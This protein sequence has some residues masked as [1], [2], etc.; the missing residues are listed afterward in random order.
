MTIT[1]IEL[2]ATAIHLRRD[3]GVRVEPQMLD[4]DR[5]GW[6]LM[7]FRV[8]T[9]DDVHADHWEIHTE[10]DE[11]VSCLNGAIRLYLRP[12]S[13]DDEPEM[14]RLTAGNAVIVPRGR[15]HRMELEGA[16]DILAVTLPRGSRLE[17][18]G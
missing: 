10:A 6:Q 9:N 17:R 7:A 4:P 14:V 18:R 13:P 8:Q 12:E 1:P 5:D 15:W 3:G 16:G 11:L 2:F